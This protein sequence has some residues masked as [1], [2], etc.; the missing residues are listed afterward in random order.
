MANTKEVSD[1]YINLVLGNI[2][3]K[4]KIGQGGMGMVYNG[5]HE[6]FA[7]EVAVKV[8]PQARNDDK[9][10]LERFIREAAQRLLYPT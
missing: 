1:P 9:Q 10:F 8:L 7:C 5:W 6:R 3:L 4:S 2:T